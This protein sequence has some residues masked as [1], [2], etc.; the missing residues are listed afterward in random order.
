MKK[1][2]TVILLIILMLAPAIVGLISY[3]I[4]K[5]ASISQKSVSKMELTDLAGKQFTFERSSEDL[6]ISNLASNPIR[7]FL[8]LNSK[9]TEEP[10]LPEPLR[11]EEYYKA[12]Y[13]S[14]GRRVDYK[15]YFTP[16]AEYC[17]YMDDTGRAF[18]ITEE[19][20][21]A[22][23][24]S[25]YGMSLFDDAVIPTMTLASGDV[26]EPSVID[27]KYVSAG[28]MT[29]EY[30]HEAT[31]ADSTEHTIS[32][33]IEMYFDI[34]PDILTLSVVQDGETVYE[35]LYEGASGIAVAVGSKIQVTANAAWTDDGERG[36]SG[37]A[38]YSFNAVYLD[39]PVFYL[40]ENSVEVGDFVVLTAKNVSDPATISFKSEPDIGCTPI[41]FQDGA[42]YRALIPIS[43]KTEHPES[44]LFTCTA[45]G[46]SQE[47]NMSVTARRQKSSSRSEDLTGL[48]AALSNV[49]STQ[50]A[51]KYFSGI[52]TDPFTEEKT[53]NVGF[54]N[55]HPDSDGNE[56]VHEGY[57]YPADDGEKIC[58]VNNGVVIYNGEIGNCGNV[59]VID[60]GFG[61]MTTYVFL[62]D[63]TVQ[64]GDEVKT[65]DRIGT[66]VKGDHIHLEL[67][68]FGNPVDIDTLWKNGVVTN[69]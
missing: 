28:D 1:R 40:G 26:I 61:L 39:K 46:A 31:E 58:A 36:Y 62:A 34:Q 33:G 49:Y 4:V 38:T 24:R 68:V 47:I 20:A 60:H 15:Y 67:T 56:S 17:Y 21:M 29:S 43:I 5:N 22:F 45:D 48:K 41:F 54:Y 57:D 50:T 12:T 64:V 32:G 8:Q 59:I 25:E 27:W 37:E 10:A 16:S 14:Y 19:Y 11:G 7:F 42:Y 52:F 35:G 23:L 13:T 66:G 51:V 53:A 69:D 55:L 2:A 3:Q 30:K 65:G 6:D 44:Y 18:K 9:A 63:T